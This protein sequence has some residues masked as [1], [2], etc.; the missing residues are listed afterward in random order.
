MLA[1][2]AMNRLHT[3]VIWAERTMGWRPSAAATR[4]GGLLFSSVASPAFRKLNV[5]STTA[6]QMSPLR[7]WGAVCNV[8]SWSERLGYFF[9]SAGSLAIQTSPLRGWG[10]VCNVAFQALARRGWKGVSLWLN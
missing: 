3:T 7:G 8:H 4:L 1:M 9:I 10:T 5:G 2:R 6:I